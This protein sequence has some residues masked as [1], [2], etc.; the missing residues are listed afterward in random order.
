MLLEV[1]CFREVKTIMLNPLTIFTWGYWGWGNATRR[2]VEAVDAVER[3]RGYSPPFF[4]D[5]RWRRTG[6]AQGFVDDAFEKVAGGE[7]YRWIQGLGNLAIDSGDPNAIKIANPEAAAELLDLA[8]EAASRRQRIIFFCACEWPRE[9]GKRCHRDEDALLGVNEAQRR[10]VAVEIVEWP[11]GD[12]ITV[13]LHLSTERVRQIRRGRK[14]I[15][16]PETQLPLAT[17]AGMPHGSIAVLKAPG[18]EDVLAIVGPAC[19]RDGG[20]VL[21]IEGGVQSG[22]QFQTVQ[23]E[24]QRLRTARGLEPRVVEAAGAGVSASAL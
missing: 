2:L 13:D 14:S 1:H 4:V 23:Q 17:A 7:R 3:A 16:L 10:G 21:P 6:R 11:G 22:S 5:V 8:A 12:P 20:W 9:I 18:L 19:F 24:A 15:P